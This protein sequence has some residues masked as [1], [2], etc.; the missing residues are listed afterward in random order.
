[1]G[2]IAAAVQDKPAADP[3]SKNNTLALQDAPFTY[4]TLRAIARTEFVPSGL[5]GNVP[6]VLA[7]VFVGREMGLPPMEAIRSIDMIDGNP[8][9]SGELLGRLIREKGHRVVL[10]EQSARRCELIGMRK[11]DGTDIKSPLHM[12]VEFTWEDAER[13]ASKGKKLVDKYNW[14]NYPRV[15]LYWRCLTMLARQHFPDAIG[16]SR[17]SYVPGEIVGDFDDDTEAPPPPIPETQERVEL[18]DDDI[19]DAEI[20]YDEDDDVD[21]DEAVAQAVVLLGPDVDPS[22]NMPDLEADLRAVYR[23]MEAGGVWTGDALHGALRKYAQVEHVG[24]LRK[25][26]LVA[27][28]QKTWDA[29]RAAIPPVQDAEVIYDDGDPERPFDEETT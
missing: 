14:R 9:P 7:A 1:M 20:I 5:R 6:A 28:S 27:F 29:A 22:R 2:D 21:P 17:I 25:A 18:E 23:L 11:E 4:E 26:E 24:D 12:T 8:T 3:S 16:A 19:T 15:M 10:V 13:V